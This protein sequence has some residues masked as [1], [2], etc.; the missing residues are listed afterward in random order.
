MYT[1]SKPLDIFRGIINKYVNLGNLLAE[2][3]HL[4]TI[5]VPKVVTAGLAL[6][7]D[8]ADFVHEGQ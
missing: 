6:L 4:M 1:K 8:G 5:V 7:S 3:D 2:G